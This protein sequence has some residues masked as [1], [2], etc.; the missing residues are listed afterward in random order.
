MSE[1]AVLAALRRLGIPKEEMSGHGF[2]ATSRTI[3]REQLKIEA[4]YIEHEL[5]HQVIDPNGRAYNRASF[6]A[7]RRLMMQCWADYL[8]KLKSGEEIPLPKPVPLTDIRMIQVAG[9]R[10]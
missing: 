10:N 7:E 9:Y 5:G 2:R 1:N 8:D 3:L 4:E 6:L